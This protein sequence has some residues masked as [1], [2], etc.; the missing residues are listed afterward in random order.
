MHYAQRA[1]PDV[2]TRSTSKQYRHSTAMT[3]LNQSEG[4]GHSLTVDRAWKDVADSV[5]EWLKA[6]R[7]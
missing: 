2:V 3:G 7:L 6:K 4:R 5:L 1:V